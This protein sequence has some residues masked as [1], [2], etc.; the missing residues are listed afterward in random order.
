MTRSGTFELQDDELYETIVKLYNS[1]ELIRGN[2]TFEQFC[3]RMLT[4]GI[5]SF[6][7][8]TLAQM[9]KYPQNKT[10]SIIDILQRANDQKK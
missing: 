9:G 4:E 5:I 8:T 10:Q 1:L 3:G 7:S 2:D 6:T